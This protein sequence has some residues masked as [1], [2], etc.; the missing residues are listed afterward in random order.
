MSA[1]KTLKLSDNFDWHARATEAM[2]EVE[3]AEAALNEI[4]ANGEHGSDEYNEAHEARTAARKK[5]AAI[6]RENQ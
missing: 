1:P 4:V 5:H 6:L 2:R 3:A